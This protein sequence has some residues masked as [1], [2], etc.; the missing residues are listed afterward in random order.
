VLNCFF[1]DY[2]HPSVCKSTAIREFDRLADSLRS[3]L[4]RH[5]GVATVKLSFRG[6]VWRQHLANKG[7]SD[8]GP[9]RI[10][11]S[12]D[13]QQLISKGL[14]QPTYSY[15]LNHFGQGLKV[16][17]PIRMA[18]AVKFHHQKRKRYVRNATGDLVPCPTIPAETLTLKF[19]TCATNGF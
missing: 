19:G 5:G 2:D 13:L 11:E 17:Y 4:S 7:V 10:Y 15:Y 12:D 6:D 16:I 9:Y 3:G 14:L 1:R 18:F 8:R